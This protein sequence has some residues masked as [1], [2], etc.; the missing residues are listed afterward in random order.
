MPSSKEQSDCPTL[1][2]LPNTGLY[3]QVFVWTRVVKKEVFHC[4]FVDA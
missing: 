1:S 3:K 4:S 2:I